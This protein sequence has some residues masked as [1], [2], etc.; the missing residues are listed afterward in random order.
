[1]AFNPAKI[2]IKR[3][4]AEAVYNP[5][6]VT[7]AGLRVSGAEIK[8]TIHAVAKLLDALYPP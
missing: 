4:R 1:M 7:A 2:T 5:D 6:A 8:P 3:A